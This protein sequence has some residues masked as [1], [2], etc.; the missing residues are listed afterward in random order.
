MSKKILLVFFCMLLSIG[1]FYALV[2]PYSQGVL[3]TPTISSPPI[4]KNDPTSFITS[5][6]TPPSTS[7]T[8]YDLSRK[9]MLTFGV[10]HHY[11]TYFDEATIE[12]TLDIDLYLNG[13][14][15]SSL[16][17]VIM[18]I[19]NQ[20]STTLTFGDKQILTY[21]GYDK[22]EASITEIKVNGVA[23]NNLPANLFLQAD[24]FVDRIYDFASQTSIV[25]AFPDQAITNDMDCDGTEDQLLISWDPIDGAEEYQLEWFH[26]ND[27]D[28]ASTSDLNINFKMNSTRITTKCTNYDLSLIFDQGYICYR[29]RGVGRSG[30]STT[31]D[32]LLF[33]NWSTDDGDMTVN[34]LPTN[35]RFYVD[36]TLAFDIYKNWQYSS[37]YAEEGKKKEVISFF[38]GSL[39]NRQMVTKINSR[40]NANNNA[41]VGETIYDYQGRPAVQVLPVP[42][43]AP[44]DACVIQGAQSTLK[45]YENFNKNTDE[46]PYSKEDFDVDG[47]A[48]CSILL[49]GMSDA[50]GA[51]NY[52]SSANDDLTGSQAFLPDANDYPFSQVEYTPDNTGRIRRQGGVGEEFQL[53][54]GHETQYFY[55]HPLQDQIDRLFGSEVGDAT[56]YQKNMVVD[57]NGQVS[58]SYLDQEG[59]V[60]ATSLAGEA[61]TTVMELN[62]G[63]GGTTALSSDLFVSDA[64]GNATANK[65][66]IDGRSKLFNQV[67]TVSSETDLTIQYGL[68]IPAFEDDCLEENVCFSCVYD[69]AI[70]VRNQCGDLISP[71]EYAT[72]KTGRF[73]MVEGAVVFKLD[74]EDFEDDFEFTISHD[75]VPVGTYQITKRL[76]VNE[77]AIQ[78]YLDM[79]LDT[80]VNGIN[81]CRNSLDDFVDIEESNSDID[82]CNEDFSCDECVTNLGTLLAYIEE[83][84]TESEYYAELEVCKAPCKSDSYYEIMREVLLAD[85]MPG[86]QYGEY[87]NNQGV[88]QPSVYQLSV[89]N[90][91]NALPIATASWK[92]PKYDVEATVQNFYFDEDGVTRSRI[93]LEDVVINGSN[94]VTAS[95][96]ALLSNAPIGTQAFFDAAV[97]RYYS[98]PEYLLN[99]ADFITYYGQNPYWANSLVTY[100]P[101]YPILKLYKTYYV[102]V[103]AGDAYTS[104]SYDA[105]L[106]GVNTWDDA[107]T[108]NLIN[109]TYLSPTSPINAR[110]NYPLATSTTHP[111]DP[112]GTYTDHVKMQNKVYSY[113]TIGT[114]TYSMMEIAAMMTRCQTGTVGTAPAPSCTKWGN[115][116]PGYTTL[117]NEQTRDAEWL[118]FRGMYIAAKQELQHE[119]A[120]YL[121][122]NDP[123]YLGYNGCIGNDNF[124]AFDNGFLHPYPSP[125]WING[126]F[127]NPD[128]PC[129]IWNMAKY[130]SKDLRFGSAFDY[131]NNDPA[132]VAY[133]QYLMTGKCPIAAS[134]EQ[135]LAQT[136][137]MGLLDDASFTM[138]VLPSLSGLVMTMSN[139]SAPTGPVPALVWSQTGGTI[140][141]D[142]LE[143][144]WDEGVTNFGTFRLEKGSGSIS[145]DWDDIVSFNNIV[146]TNHVGS[147]YEFTIKAQVNVGGTVIVQNLT[148]KTTLQIGGCN[149]VEKCELNEL[150]EDLQL[151]MQVLVV[152]DDFA[153]TT[154]VNLTAAP[155]DDFLSTTISY[156]LTPTP[157]TAYWTHSLAIPGFQI[158]DGSAVMKIAINSFTPS[159]F[160]LAALGTVASI[161]EVRAG[162]NNTLQ[163]VCLD[164][165]GNHLVTLNCDLIRDNVTPISVGECALPEPL[166]CEGQEFDNLHDLKKLLESVLPAQNEP[167]NLVTT[168]LWTAN[169]NSTMPSATT[170][171]VGST[172]SNLAGDQFLTFDMP[173]GCDLVL[174][175]DH[176]QGAGFDF[177]AITSVD[178]MTLVNP[179]NNYGSYYDFTLNVSYLSGGGTHTAILKGTSCIKLMK[180]TDCNDEVEIDLDVAPITFGNNFPSEN[181]PIPTL[182][183]EPETTEII[184][185]DLYEDY[186]TAYNNFVAV[187]AVTPTCSNYAV[188]YPMLTYQE[189]LDHNFCCAVGSS[190]MISFIGS[191]RNFV[192]SGYTSCPP[193]T[194][195]S[196]DYAECNAFGSC[197]AVWAKYRNIVTAFNGSPWAVANGVTLPD[198]VLLEMD[199]EDIGANCECV[200]EYT[201][202]LL[203]YLTAPANEALPQITTPIAFCASQPVREPVSTCKNRYSDYFNFM[204]SYNEVMSSTSGTEID[205]IEYGDFMDQNLCY[206]LDE[207]LSE[208]NMNLDG[209]IAEPDFGD[210]LEFCSSQTVST[211]CL[212]DT[213]TINFETFELVYDDPCLEFY[214][215]NIDINAQLAFNE[216]TQALQTDFI[217]RYVKHCLSA[218][219]YLKMDYREL[220]HHFTLYY[221]DQAGNLVKTI[222]PEGVEFLDLTDPDVK[223]AIAADRSNGTHQ[224]IT[225]HRLGTTYLYNS[226][227]QLVAQNMPDQDPMQILEAVMPNGLPVG[228][229]T[230]GMQMV[231]SN[232]GYATGYISVTNVPMGTRGYLFKTMNGGQNWTRVT[233]T[234]AANFKEIRMVS[235]TQGFAIGQQGLFFITNDNAVSWDLVNTYSNP[236]QADF[237]AM[238]VNSSRVYLLTKTGDIYRYP[239]GSGYSGTIA[240]LAAAP[241]NPAGYSVVEYKDFILPTTIVANNSGIIYIATVTNGQTYDAVLLRNTTGSYAEEFVQVADLGAASFYNSTDGAVAGVDGNVSLLSGASGSYV[242]GL[243][244]SDATG[245]IAQIVMLDANRGVAKVIENGI[246]II[247]T[248]VDGGTNWDLLETGF[249][250]ANLSLNKRSSTAIEVLIQGFE[251][252]G[253]SN[254]AYS[255]TLFMNTSDVVSILN[256]TPNLQQNLDLKVVT[257][258]VDGSNTYYFG[259]GSDNKLYRSNSF[260]T[261]GSTVNY[262]QIASASTLPS[263][264]VPKQIVCVKNGSGISVNILATNGKVY[265]TTST[266][267]TANTYNTLNTGADLSG[268]TTVVAID[269]M[270]F[271]SLNYLVGYNSSDTKIYHSLSSGTSFTV[272]T[273]TIS[274]SSSVITNL[275]V[276]GNQITL[277]G[278]IGGLFTS[279]SIT[280]TGT[281]IA[282]S[283]R[284]PHR[285]TKLVGARLLAGEMAIYGENG[286]VLTRAISSSTVVCFVKPIGTVNQVNGVNEFVSSGT[287]YYLFAG[288][289]GYLKGFHSTT[290][291]A[292]PDYFSST[293]VLISDHSANLA[294]T[295]IAVNGKVVYVVGEQGRVYYTPNILTDYFMPAAANITA[296][297]LRSVSIITD[298][299]NKCI[300]AGDNTYMARFNSNFGTTQNQIFGPA[301]RDVH[302]ADAQTGTIIGDHYFVRSTSTSD[303]SWKICLPAA[304]SGGSIND[305]RKVWTFKTTGANPYMIIGGV[306]YFAQVSDNVITPE[307]SFSGTVGDIQF[308]E[309]T[310]LD[311]YYTVGTGLHHLS[312]S[313]STYPYSHLP[314]TAAF[315][316]APLDINAI[317]VFDNGGIAMASIYG[318]AY[319]YRPSTNAITAL[320][321]TASSPQNT[322]R[323]IYFHDHVSGVVVGD[324]GNVSFITAT[325]NPI[326]KE[327]TSTT[328][329]D[330]VATDP[331]GAIGTDYNITCLAFGSRNTGVYGGTYTSASGFIPTYPAMVRYLKIE[332][333]LYS[334]HFYYDRLGRIVVSQNSRQLN[335]PFDPTDNEY[336]YTIYDALGRVTEA[337]AKFENFTSNNFPNIFGAYVGGSFVPTVVNDTKMNDWLEE[338]TYKRFEVTKSYYDETNTVI[339]GEVTSLSSLNTATQRKRIV[340]VTYSDIYSE[341]ANDYDHATHYDYD[342]HGNVKTLYQDNRKIKDMAGVGQHRLKKMDYVYDLISGNVHRVDYQTGMIDQWHHAYEYDADNRII[343]AYTTKSTP[344]TSTVSSSASLQNEPTIN[345]LWDKE[346]EY[347]YYK[348]GPLARTVL[349]EQKV[350]GQDYIYTLHGWIKSVNSNTLDATRDPG[351]DAGF[352]NHSVAKDAYG[353]SLHYFDG[354]YTSA[355]GNNNFIA[356][357]ST[358]DMISNSANLYNGNIGRMITTLTHPDTRVVLPLGNAYRYDQLNRLREANSFNNLDLGTNT[359][360]SA[361][362]VMYHNDFTFDANGNIASQN[363]QNDGG[364]D[365]DDLTYNYYKDGL[366]KLLSNRLYSVNDAVSSGGSGGD[367]DDMGPFDNTDVGVNVNNNYQYDKEGRLVSDIQE[368]LYIFWKVNGKPGIIYNT[369]GSPTK[370]S[371]SFD[372]DAFGHRIAKHIY[373]SDLGYML[374]KSI[375]YILDAQGNVMSVY[376]RKIEEEESVSY[377][378]TEKYIYGSSRLGVHTEVVPVLA[379]LYTA[380]DM[381]D[382]T[383]EI[384]YRNYELTNHLGN[385]LSV[386]S[387]KVISHDNSGT[388]DY[389]L[390]DIRQSTDYSPFGVLLAKRDLRL[391]DPST[392][393]LVARGRFG[394]QGQES[395][396]EL[397]GTGNSINFEYRMHDPRLGRFFAI[398]PLTADYPWYT[399]YSFSG[400]KVIAFKELEGAEESPA[401]NQVVYILPQTYNITA[402][403][404][405]DYI[406]SGQ[407]YLNKHHLTWAGKKAFE[408]SLYLGSRTMG[409]DPIIM[410]WSFF[411]LKRDVRETQ[412]SEDREDYPGQSTAID[413]PRKQDGSYDRR[414]KLSGK[415]ISNNVPT[416]GSKGMGYL[417]LALAVGEIVYNISESSSL[418]NSN[419]TIDFQTNA[420]LEALHD[421]Q[422]SIGKGWV[423]QE[424]IEPYQMAVITNVLMSGKMSKYDQRV[425]FR[426][427][428][429]GKLR[430]FDFSKTVN[431]AK[432]LRTKIALDAINIYSNQVE[433]LTK[434]Y[435][436]DKPQ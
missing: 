325:I 348:H 189:F 177:D 175:Y 44:S 336:S 154:A 89:F 383:H 124:F 222:P 85:V 317:H 116:I 335:D 309:S 300:V 4:V 431:F 100:H 375:Y 416:A 46:V 367:I 170:S 372:Y 197:E 224:V 176:S 246:G 140:P 308:E 241:T 435:G 227:N 433:R 269:Q 391:T 256:Q 280:S 361:G 379:S 243:H 162:Y 349:G 277:V 196:D 365:I 424:Y 221:Y 39:R 146:Y 204:T 418:S 251:V 32:R 266:V 80:S 428:D 304:I 297:N 114:T 171:I 218:V 357:Q 401:T 415:L 136:A 382:V 79:Y 88:V 150:G 50:I 117:Q 430:S 145:Y 104:E 319:Y 5:F 371:I 134:F 108:A 380:Y 359:W 267:I 103:I 161:S 294:L 274:L 233:N 102:P 93:Y 63:L 174:T 322:C 41:I 138:D 81:T 216:Q 152:A 419:Q 386:V 352:A 168:G 51:S 166:Q 72:K 276:H 229:I 373:A 35:S 351:E 384:G 45:Y 120:I 347:N 126:E 38:D 403:G 242:Q 296:N 387:D 399:P 23:Q 288:A 25:P 192:V 98:H 40:Y 376:E 260:T 181:G 346:V 358:S 293:G 268:A 113:M 278:T 129:Y 355:S 205:I 249:A 70:E 306:N 366:G 327:I 159:T 207:Y 339:S 29:V 263:G 240:S 332:S 160:S 27:I 258:Y 345:P 247:R 344:L 307:S 238:E 90:T 122:I 186:V 179:V 312:V 106:M 34:D 2:L 414:N 77:D 213:A 316:N 123:N 333:G 184:C 26:I 323:D 97:N 286:L 390:A 53:G 396:D 203:E 76:T 311:G 350:Q 64:N 99:V 397:K 208:L 87:S 144:S 427:G 169:L 370:K 417:G 273:T 388:V 394:F 83:G 128:Q 59:R 7:L 92:L 285:L 22:I 334:S 13:S 272:F 235:S 183:H 409:P 374:E 324:K 302:F 259:I 33:T 109:S 157:T 342:I 429:L 412:G 341:D 426:R 62:S 356:D 48:A 330:R 180:C 389:W 422:Y 289:N 314:L 185:Q 188:N 110:F 107:V 230:T 202:Y 143:V 393:N 381:D 337:G 172:T 368:E 82:D 326:T 58:V 261:M 151:L 321:V 232:Q 287:T 127:F 219:E 167:F 141:P 165:S 3:T 12:I 155:Y 211:P 283:P 158:S 66:S 406:G 133:Q 310:P 200:A 340:H 214:E 236:I 190:N 31:T 271:S 193:A 139:F 369:T 217:D 264:I 253:S 298:P 156:T 30:G 163:I 270:T 17:G 209:L 16:T 291:A 331:T 178:E 164:A 199:S 328:G 364:T 112:Y 338:D 19:K 378:Q 67:I 362:T 65:L 265:R 68:E 56:H 24:V 105:A 329:L 61:P 75:L 407:L 69:L 37:T 281:S 74:C 18:E 130:K 78:A 49:H 343:N 226:L 91:S 194:A 101:E 423:P 290:W 436:A 55:G 413:G 36:A 305:L 231:S 315:K 43:K 57:P 255:K 299:S 148:G 47:E 425:I 14:L 223:A 400:N 239:I 303:A 210:L 212:L 119:R 191:L 398:D 411:A 405:V 392:S 295:D 86:G 60:I 11:E 125:P 279:G 15:S 71:L 252:V 257:T 353:Y 262:T 237:V 318:I 96:P 410:D 21:D 404:V 147:F 6:I 363:R 195:L 275:A 153:S 245:T 94:Q 385:V 201:L 254:N 215:S 377:N 292:Q 182:A 354:D 28:I 434:K 187:Q 9:A 228:F 402:E 149:F 220:E 132:D 52:Y 432:E 301:Y 408:N 115:D 225:G 54:S 73:E 320:H 121:S 95:T 282:F 248:T 137:D 142:I 360:L 111:W 284:K 42:V 313:G 198:S 420:A 118:I 234:L 8:P 84:G 135:L 1:K 421:F 244:T 173:N 10:N 250:N 395:D 20:S 206:C 131:V